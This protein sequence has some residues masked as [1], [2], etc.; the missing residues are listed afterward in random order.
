[1][2]RYAN[3]FIKY[4]FVD[5]IVVAFYLF[6]RVSACR[7]FFLFLPCTGKWCVCANWFVHYRHAKTCLVGLPGTT[8]NYLR[9][10]DNLKT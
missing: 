2:Y 9:P 5:V 1:M 6:G 8:T 4:M 3:W 10:D 7:A